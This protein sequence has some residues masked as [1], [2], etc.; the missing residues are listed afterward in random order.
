MKRPLKRSAKDCPFCQIAN[1]KLPVSQR[2]A[3]A[4]MIAFDDIHPHAPIHVLV[5]PKKHIASLADIT[6]KDKELMGKMIYRCKE[7]A[8]KLNIADSGYRVTVNV[9][10]WGG[11]VVPHLHFHLLGGAPL[12]ERLS[13]YT[14][15]AVLLSK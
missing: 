5:V 1:G 14:E 6:P 13:S 15:A 7:L 11:Q 10:K 3:D 8:K 9:G 12:T 4:D 2:F